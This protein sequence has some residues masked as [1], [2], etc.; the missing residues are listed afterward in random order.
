M[1][2]VLGDADKKRLEQCKSEVFPHDLVTRECI[3]NGDEEFLRYWI[4]KE[5]YYWDHIMFTLAAYDQ[6][7]FIQEI[8]KIPVFTSR[9]PIEESKESTHE[10]VET[11]G[12]YSLRVFH[13]NKGEK[14]Q[15]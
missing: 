7:D 14:T 1:G 4:Y 6:K 5:V 15:I 11:G 12:R 2:G 8:Y 13:R 3:E 9:D 10:T